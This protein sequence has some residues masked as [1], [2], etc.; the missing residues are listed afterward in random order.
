[1]PY[2]NRNNGS[3]NK[4]RRAGRNPSPPAGRKSRARV[5]RTSRGGRV[6]Q[7]GPNQ[8][9]MP[10][11]NGKPG[12]CMKG[13]THM[14]GNTTRRG[15]NGNGGNG[16]GGNGNRTTRSANVVNRTRLNQKRSRTSTPRQTGFKN[17]IRSTASRY[18]LADGTPYSGNVFEQNGIYY[19]TKGGGMEGSSRELNR[20]LKKG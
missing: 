7:C 14:G 20:E 19:T 10:P 5:G 6:G 16:N 9:W 18:F 4:G 1:M 12:Y 11:A 8:H 2:H 17:Q 15:R 13:K 3:M